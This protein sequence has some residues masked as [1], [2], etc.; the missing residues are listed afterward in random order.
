MYMDVFVFIC[1]CIYMHMHMYL[2]RNYLVVGSLVC[3]QECKRATICVDHARASLQGV[4]AD[5]HVCAHVYVMLHTSSVAWCQPQDFWK[6]AYVFLKGL[7]LAWNGKNDRQREMDV[8]CTNVGPFCFFTL[9]VYYHVADSNLLRN[10]L[11]AKIQVRK[12]NK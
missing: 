12:N 7:I 11:H 3:M 10:T 8:K 1:I 4:G 9:H 5:P 6:I 2:T